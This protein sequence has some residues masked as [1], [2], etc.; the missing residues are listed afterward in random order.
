MK[1]CRDC[2]ENLIV[3]SWTICQRCSR[4]DSRWVYTCNFCEDEKARGE[5]A[6]DEGMKNLGKIKTCNGC[7]EAISNLKKERYESW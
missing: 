7:R 3:P 1:A 2:G 5:F 4:R 6:P